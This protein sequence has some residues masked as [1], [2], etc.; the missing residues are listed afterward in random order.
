MIKGSDARGLNRRGA[1]DDLGNFL[2]DRGLA[3]L[4]V[5]EVQR[6]DQLAGV[7]GRGLHRDHAR[8]MLGRDVLEHR[9][10][11]QRLDVARQHVVEHGLRRRARTGSPSRAWRPAFPTP[12]AAAAGRTS[13][14]A[15]WC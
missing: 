6:V 1:A 5:D 12:A 15:S 3:R 14:S 11:H 13:P 8:G 2:R 9:L 10:V 4:V 7:V